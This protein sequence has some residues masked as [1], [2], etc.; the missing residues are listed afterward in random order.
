MEAARNF[1][2]ALFWTIIGSGVA[3]IGLVYA[4]IRNFKTDMRQEI[5][6]LDNRMFHLA[7]GKTFK[8]ILLEE[9]LQEQKK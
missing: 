8:E 7:M 5:E 3:V 9:K 4:F 1:D 6:K 2:W